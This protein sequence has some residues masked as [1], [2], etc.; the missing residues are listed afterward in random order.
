M[1]HV[2]TSVPLIALRSFPA[3]P[4]KEAFHRYLVDFRA[5]HD[6]AQLLHS[7]AE[8]NDV[9][10]SQY[11]RLLFLPPGATYREAARLLLSSWHLAQ[12]ARE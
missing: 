4:D 6:D 1:L 10:P 2:V 7:L 5:V 9:L 8:C 12:G 11:A 3:G